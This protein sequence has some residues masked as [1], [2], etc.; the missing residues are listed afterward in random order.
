MQFRKVD[1]LQVT[2]KDNGEPEE[3]KYDARLE[4]DQDLR[5]LRIAHEKRG[6][7]EALY[8]EVAFSDVTGVL[9]EQS[10]SPRWKT[11]I[12]LS[13]P[14]SGAVL[15]GAQALA[16]DRVQGRVRLHAAGQEQPAADPRRAERVRVRGGDDSRGLMTTVDGPELACTRSEALLPPPWPIRASFR[17]RSRSTSAADGRPSGGLFPNPREIL[18]PSSWLREGKIKA[19]CLNKRPSCW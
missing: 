17:V 14:P 10:K 6:A 18:F 11:A 2:T 3:K 16:D 12:F 13:A 8:A 5:V 9:Y 19:R 7:D 4:I 15:V 1:Y